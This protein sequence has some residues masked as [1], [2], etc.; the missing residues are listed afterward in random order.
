MERSYSSASSTTSSRRSGRRKRRRMKH[1]VMPLKKR[2]GKH[3]VACDV[4]RVSNLD[5]EEMEQSAC[6]WVA[7][8]IDDPLE[9][10]FK[11]DVFVNK[12]QDS[13][14]DEMSYLEDG[15]QS[16]NSGE[17][18]RELRKEMH[19]SRTDSRYDTKYSYAE[20]TFDAD[21][22]ENN[23]KYANEDEKTDANYSEE[24][25]FYGVRKGKMKDGSQL[26][27][28]SPIPSPRNRS[29]ISSFSDD[30]QS[31]FSS[32]GTG[33]HVGWTSDV[34][35]SSGPEYSAMTDES[36]GEGGHKR[37]RRGSKE[38]YGY[39]KK[40]GEKSGNILNALE[41]GI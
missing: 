12:D 14:D 22:K 40:D 27:R 38:F 29:R 41:H 17:F 5:N 3:E 11:E 37:T 31:G 24:K 30:G 25:T 19:E 15:R 39:R 21:E 32:E 34:G 36:D 6:F 1:T 33:M 8:N 4:H 16:Q 18:A 35:V 7:K 26:E 10:S 20:K 9:R 23:A 2:A 13:S 28:V